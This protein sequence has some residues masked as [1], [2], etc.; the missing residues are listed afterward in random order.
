MQSLVGNPIGKLVREVLIKGRGGDAQRSFSTDSY[1]LRWSRSGEHD[2]IFVA[3]YQ[4]A[5][6]LMYVEPLLE[7]VK[8]SFCSTFATSLSGGNMNRQF[9]FLEDFETLRQEAE[10]HAKAQKASG[11]RAP[12]PEGK[13]SSPSKSEN[14]SSKSNESVS[15]QAASTAPTITDNLAKLKARKSKKNEVQIGG[16]AKAKPMERDNSKE[17]RDWGNRS[18]KKLTKEEREQLDHTVG[19]EAEGE[20]IQIRKMQQEV[21]PEGA[22]YE[23]SDEEPEPEVS[24]GGSGI[25][26]RIGS[27]LKS[28]LGQSA[29]TEAD[30]APVMKQ[31]STQLVTKN[32]AHDTA[33][34]VVADVTQQLIGQ[35]LGTFS[36]IAPAFNAALATTLER[37]LTPTEST[38]ILR[39]VARAK[40]ARRPYVIVFVGVNGVGKSTSLAKL[41]YY[42]QCNN[43]GKVLLAAC[44]TFRS[45]AVEQIKVHSKCLEVDL[46]A[47]GYEADAAVVAS[48]AIKKAS[49]EG[50]DVV[51]VDTAGRMQNNG[52]LMQA[53]AKLIDTNNPDLV[54]FVGEALAGNDAV[55]QVKLFN[56]ALEE[57]STADSPR[58]VDGMILTKFDTVDDK[59]GAAISMAYTTGRPIFFVG[60]GQRYVDLKR[61]NVKKVV[62]SLLK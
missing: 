11:A 53:L 19:S 6:S 62:G 44:D 24:E 10:L 22:S 17:K 50:Y 3:V 37:I 59:V 40:K 52:P 27:M 28:K 9:D 12:K 1:C 48:H 15:S 36:R 25:F 21:L 55:D 5:L 54:L 35:T 34:A 46:Y 56:Q 61:V 57:H 26:S 39:G 14:A 60:T 42:L 45:G 41:C 29:L 51:L 33:E 47:E 8:S 31:M 23:S 4:K 18:N 58:L 16:K 32:V 43:A 38:D 2:L 7:Q 20:E 49:D 30:L 13:V